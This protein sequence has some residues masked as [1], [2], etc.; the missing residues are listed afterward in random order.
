M[1]KRIEYNEIY[2]V[3]D[4]ELNLHMK[5]LASKTVTEACQIGKDY[6]TIDVAAL[7][8][9]WLITEFNEA[10]KNELLKVR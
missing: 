4:S 9:Q 5:E 1:K 2:M 6:S 7:L 8:C 3:K 10:I